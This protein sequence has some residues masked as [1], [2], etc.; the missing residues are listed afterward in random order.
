MRPSPNP[1]TN[2]GRVVA[3]KG[4]V[5]SSVFFFSFPSEFS[6]AVFSECVSG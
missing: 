5:K 1:S 6:P 4:I 3:G 2:G